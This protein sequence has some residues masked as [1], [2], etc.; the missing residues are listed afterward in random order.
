MNKIFIISDTH[1]GH[2]KII[3]FEAKNRPFATI[4]E[5][6]EELVRRW[7]EAVNPKDTVWHLGDVLFGRDTFPILGRLNG[8]KKLVLGNH[9]KYPTRLYLEYFNQV[10]GTA[11]VK[12]C[13]L[14]HIPVHPSQFERYKLNFHGHLHGKKLQDSR[15]INV[16]AE[17]IGLTPL[18][19]K[20]I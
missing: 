10:V 6:D 4:E 11:E 7:N 8:I 1:F 20:G 14:S 5:H 3:E 13:I 18:W 2:K 15:Y 9:D 16:S 17:C 19:F 12:N